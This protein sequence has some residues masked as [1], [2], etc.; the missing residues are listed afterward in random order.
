MIE[1]GFHCA[2]LIAAA[3]NIRVWRAHDEELVQVALRKKL[4][5]HTDG[6]LLGHHPEQAHHVWVL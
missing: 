4:K 2:V 1:A 5:Q 3:A 6:L